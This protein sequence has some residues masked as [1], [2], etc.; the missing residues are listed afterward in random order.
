MGNKMMAI[1]TTQEYQ[2]QE[3]RLQ[4]IKNILEEMTKKEDIDLSKVVALRE[5]A[6]TLAKSLKAYLKT[7]FDTK[8]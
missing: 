2:V 7:T 8:N 1:E 4:E 6:R 3:S 5:E